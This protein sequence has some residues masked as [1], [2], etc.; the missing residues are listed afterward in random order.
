[1]C[2]WGL[3]PLVLQSLSLLTTAALPS[4]GLIPQ[5]GSEIRAQ[6][7]PRVGFGQ[8]AWQKNP[9]PAAKQ[10]QGWKRLLAL[11]SQPLSQP[12]PAPPA[13]CSPVKFGP[14]PSPWRGPANRLPQRI[15][16]STCPTSP[17]CGTPGG[18]ITPQT[19]LLPEETLGKP[20]LPFTVR[21]GCCTPAGCAELL[22]APV[23][24]ALLGGEW[25]D[26]ACFMSPASGDTAR[27]ALG[28]PRLPSSPR[29]C[30]DGGDQ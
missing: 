4:P 23:T 28:S 6:T 12:P 20:T 18:Q 22:T 25:R 11:P 10:R 30:R 8:P 5:F 14:C 29:R 26:I 9:F 3:S 27:A 15:L 24:A 19:R 2:Y 21:G 7:L 1:M 16:R 13:P 17:R